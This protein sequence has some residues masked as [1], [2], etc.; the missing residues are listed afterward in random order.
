MRNMRKRTMIICGM[1]SG[2][3]SVLLGAPHK[4]LLEAQTAVDLMKG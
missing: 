1:I 3:A 4:I 2:L